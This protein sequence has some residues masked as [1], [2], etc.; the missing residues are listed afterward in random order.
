MARRAGQGAQRTSADAAL[1]AAPFIAGGFLC[2]LAALGLEGELRIAAIVAGLVALVMALPAME[3]SRAFEMGADGERKVA[4]RL[5]GLERRG[6][7]VI[8][9][10]AKGQRGNVDHVIAG[11]TGVFAVETKASRYSK[12]AL[13]QARRHATWVHRKTGAWTT[14]VVCVANQTGLR[15]RVIG[16]V[17]VMGSERI[18]R[19]VRRFD[20][21]AL[22]AGVIRSALE[23]EQGGR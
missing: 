18:S 5:R 13:E 9:D 22:D 20:G 7:V 12:S 21:T 6:F 19:F 3:R 2:F 11:P 23:G 16:G 1:R 10:V 8:H 4:R 15:P 17:W 14:P